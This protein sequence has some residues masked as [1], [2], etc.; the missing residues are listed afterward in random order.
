MSVPLPLQSKTSLNRVLHGG[1]WIVIGGLVVIVGIGI[2]LTRDVIRKARIRKEIASLEQQI[3]GLERRNEELAGLIDYFESD[4]F[5]E[6]EARAKLNVQKPGEKVI[7]VQ[8][9]SGEPTTQVAVA[10]TVAQPQTNPERW[11]NFFFAKQ[12]APETDQ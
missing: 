2:A 3:S 8:Q 1:R 5:T 6:R 11:W 4:T 7:E 9:P 12:E 10:P